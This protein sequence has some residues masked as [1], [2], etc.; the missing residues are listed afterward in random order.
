MRAAI[1]SG[2]VKFWRRSQQWVHIVVDKLLQYRIVEPADVVEFIFNPPEDEPATI[3][4]MEKGEG[5]VGFNTWTLL[6]LTL[7]KV[8]GRVDQLKK[9]LEEISR[10]EAEEQERKDAAAAAGLPFDDHPLT[11]TEEEEKQPLFPTSATL[12]IRPPEA[13]A[14]A[15]TEVSSTEALAS[16]DAIKSEQRKVLIGTVNG[17]TSHL[18]KLDGEKGW[19]HWWCLGWYKQLVRCFNAQLMQNRQ[20]ILDNSFAGVEGELGESLREILERA[21]DLL[22]E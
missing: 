17:F 18:A 15:S 3:A 5:W 22:S 8:N 11:S 6:K 21:V 7:E 4:R 16:L 1:L 14:T 19:E 13:S 20:L 9:R 2:A 12:P 10:K